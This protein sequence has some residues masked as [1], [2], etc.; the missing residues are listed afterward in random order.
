MPEDQWELECQLQQDQ[1]DDFDW[2]IGHG[3]MHQGTGP[4]SDHSPGRYT[5]SIKK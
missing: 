2:Q 5:D 4:S 3:R 1:N